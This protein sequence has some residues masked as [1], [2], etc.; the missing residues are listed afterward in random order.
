MAIVVPEWANVLFFVIIGE[1]MPQADED[2]AYRSHEAFKDF[3]G[4]LHKLSE[5]LEESIRASGGALPPEIADRYVRATRMV[6]DHGGKNYVLEFAKQL[7][8]V[9]EG[10]VQISIQIAENKVDIIVELAVLAMTLAFLDSL[11]AF[12]FGGTEAFAT[13]AKLASRYRILGM[14]TLLLKR[15]HLMPTISEMLE[16]MF[17]ALAS[18]LILMASAAPGRKPRGIDVKDLFLSGAAGALNSVFEHFFHGGKNIF[19]GLFKDKADLGPGLGRKFDA[20][21][22][23]PVP[24]PGK[25]PPAG[26]GQKI[27]ATSAD[28]TFDAA[29]AGLSEYLTGGVISGFNTMDFW[30]GAVSTLSMSALALG[31]D[32]LGIKMPDLSFLKHLNTD[33]YAPSKSGSAGGG[34]T[35]TGAG[36]Q[37]ADTHTGPAA[38]GPAAGPGLPGPHPGLAGTS[39][40]PVPT[41]SQ[42]D[43]PNPPAPAV[44]TGAGQSTGPATVSGGGSQSPGTTGAHGRSG[45]A[46]GAPAADPTGTRSPAPTEHDTLPAAGPFAD[47]ATST[48]APHPATGGRPAHAGVDAE[49]QHTP[50]TTGDLETEDT[51][52][53]QPGTGPVSAPGTGTGTSSPAQHGQ[54]AAPAPTGSGTTATVGAPTGATAAANPP[55][56]VKSGDTGQTSGA[57]ASANRNTERGGAAPGDT[58]GSDL[59]QAITAS[60]AAVTVTDASVPASDAPVTVTHTADP[61]GDVRP[62]EPAGARPGDQPATASVTTVSDPAGSPRPSGDPIDRVPDGTATDGTATDDGPGMSEPQ[63]IGPAATGIVAALAAP[64]GGKRKRRNDPD[65]DTD[66]QSAEPT[67]AAPDPTAT[68]E[69][70]AAP[71]P[72]PT[73]SRP[74]DTQAGA[75]DKG[76]TP[77]VVGGTLAAPHEPDPGGTDPEATDTADITDTTDTDDAITVVDGMSDSGDTLVGTEGGTTP[78]DGAKKAPKDPMPPRSREE[79]ARWI[80][81]LGTTAGAA[82]DPDAAPAV[83]KP[84][85]LGAVTAEEVTVAMFT[86]GGSDGDT[87][88][89]PPRPVTA[90]SV[91]EPVGPTAGGPALPAPA[92]FQ[93]DALVPPHETAPAPEPEAR[94]ERPSVED[95]GLGDRLTERLGTS[96]LMGAHVSRQDLADLEHSPALH[97]TWTLNPEATVRVGDAG[98]TPLDRARLLVRRPDLDADLAAELR[99]VPA[100]G[101]TDGTQAGTGAE[102]AGNPEQAPEPAGNPEQAPESAGGPGDRDGEHG[103]ARQAPAAGTRAGRR[104]APLRITV[105]DSAQTPAPGTTT[106]YT[107]HVTDPSAGPVFQHIMPIGVSD[108]GEPGTRDG[109][110]GAPRLVGVRQ[111]LGTPD[112]PALQV[113]ADG[114]LAVSTENE[115]REAFATPAAFERSRALLQAAGGSVRLVRDEEVSLTVRH[116]GTE[117]TLYRVRPE[118]LEDPTDVCRDLAGQILGGVPDH[119]VFRDPDGHTALGPMNAADGLKV[120]ELHHLAHAIVQ[121]V[122]GRAGPGAVPGTSWAAG[123]ARGRGAPAS[124]P[125]T[126]ASPVSATTPL[127]GQR[128][129]ALLGTGTHAPAGTRP[130]ID[131]NQD[132]WPAVGEGY[133]TQSIGSKDAEGRFTLEDHA[134]A[135]HPVDNPFGY[136][137]A[138]VVL[139]AEDDSS[140][141]TLENYA[142]RGTTQRALKDAVDRNLERHGDR[143]E[144]MR[145]AYEAE[146]S[147][148]TGRAR[149]TARAAVLATQAL[150]A[151]RDERAA[152]AHA[153][154]GDGEGGPTRTEPQAPTPA[155]RAASSALERYSGGRDLRTPGALWHMR[156]VD[157]SGQRTFHDQVAGLHEQDRPGIVVNPLTA[158]VVGAHGAPGEPGN[159]VTFAER[160][161]EPTEDDRRKLRALARRVARVGLWSH[162]NGLPLPAIGVSAGGNGV[163]DAVPAL[164]DRDRRARAT[165]ER[166]LDSA[167]AMFLDE[168]DQELS[169]LQRG[170]EP[171]TALTARDFEVRRE[172]RGRRLPETTGP[173]RAQTDPR[174]LRRQA[175]FT[176]EPHPTREQPAPTY[177]DTLDHLAQ[178]S[179]LIASFLDRSPR[180]PSALSSPGQQAG[181][182]LPFPA[183]GPTT[184]MSEHGV[185]GMLSVPPARPARP[186]SAP[187]GIDVGRLLSDIGAAEAADA[188][189]TS[190][191]STTSAGSTTSARSATAD[192]ERPDRGKGRAD[193]VPA[194]PPEDSAE[195]PDEATLRA[196]GILVEHRVHLRL[197]IGTDDDTVA[198][199]EVQTGWVERVAA[200]LGPDY[201]PAGSRDESVAHDVAEAI[202]R[203]RAERAVT[204]R[205]FAEL[206][207][208]R[209][210]TRPPRPGHNTGSPSRM[211]QLGSGGHGVGGL[212]WN[213]GVVERERALSAQYGVAIG[214][215][216]GRPNTHFSHS[217]LTRIEGVLAGLPADHLRGMVAITPGPAS[218]GGLTSEYDPNH[219]TVVVVAPY[220]LPSWIMNQF[221]RGSAWQRGA[222]DWA[223]MSEYRGFSSGGDRA[224]GLAGQRR[225][226][227]GGVSD[228][229]AQ[230]NFMKWLLRHEIGHHVDQLSNWMRDLIEQPHFGGWRVYGAGGY[231]MVVRNVLQKHGLT[232]LGETRGRNGLTLLS[233][234]ASA[235]SPRQQ[236]DRTQLFT[237][238]RAAFSDQSPDFRNR[239]ERVIRFGQLAFAHPWMLD[240]GGGDVLDIDGR[241]H[242]VSNDHQWISYLRSERDHHAVSNYQFSKPVEWFAEAY[243]AFYDPDPAPRLRMN[244]RTVHWF[245]SEL[246]A[247]L[248]HSAP[249]GPSGSSAPAGSSGGYGHTRAYPFRPDADWAAKSRRVLQDALVNAVERGEI[250]TAYT[251]G[252][253]RAL[254]AAGAGSAPADA[255]GGRE[256]DTSP[257]RPVFWSTPVTSLL[258]STPAVGPHDLPVRERRALTQRLREELFP[259]EADPTATETDDGIRRRWAPLFARA[260][261]D[262]ALLGAAERDRL[263]AG[264]GRIMAGRHQPPPIIRADV[265]PG[266]PEADYLALHDDMAA[267]IAD[268]LRRS[269]RPDLPPERRPAHLLSELLREDFGTR[270]TRGGVGGGPGK[271]LKKRLTGRRSDAGPS[272]AGPSGTG[273]FAEPGPSGHGAPGQYPYAQGTQPQSPYAPTSHAPTSYVQ[274]PYA[275]GT[276]TTP[277]APFA[278]A[279]AAAHPVP[280][281]YG[282]GSSAPHQ[283]AR[284]GSALVSTRPRDWPGDVGVQWREGRN[285]G[286]H[287]I[288]SGNGGQVVVKF[289]SDAASSVYADEFIRGVSDVHVPASRVLARGSTDA[290]AVESLIARQD[291]YWRNA[292]RALVAEYSHITVREYAE[293]TPLSRLSATERRA[294]AADADALRRIGG[295]MMVTDA[296]LGRPDRLWVNPEGGS[297]INWDNLLYSARLRRVTAIDNDTGFMDDGFN[298]AAHA[299]ELERNWTDDSI[300]HLANDLVTH[301]SGFASGLH[302]TQAAEVLDELE[303]GAREARG[304][305]GAR[306]LRHGPAVQRRFSDLLPEEEPPNA[307]LTAALAQYA[308]S[309]WDRRGA[310]RRPDSA[311]SEVAA[312]AATV[313]PYPPVDGDVRDRWADRFQ[314]AWQTLDRLA[315]GTQGRLLAEAAR[316]MAGRHR[317]PPP[318]HPGTQQH[319]YSV[320][321]HDITVLIAGTLHDYSDRPEAVHEAQAL[322]EQLRREFGTQA[323]RGA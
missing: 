311:L 288:G 212:L 216:S 265:V 86:G 42:A 144:E 154:A 158:V 30:G 96:R 253:V 125:A 196:V 108:A 11:A 198:F 230:G 66:E 306:A 26:T 103:S 295:L 39:P 194:D 279:R 82:H 303:Q 268:R 88:P 321:H 54:A 262:L 56:A 75:G 5:L 115:S 296:F 240:D 264:A 313:N 188:P 220:G 229:L 182:G 237:A 254:E 118:F 293:G 133:L 201:S 179:P 302:R 242:H 203:E 235:F 289:H 7:D 277:Q 59:D 309:R 304:R 214:P 148:V 162:R 117:R 205:R 184:P 318:D 177:S 222:M 68:R 102:P 249:S 145:A 166:R 127:P 15:I 77:A 159:R 151:V 112:H 228:V 269:P 92:P 234:V 286:V 79:I 287:V 244:P 257:A 122:D 27:A 282:S 35:M 191:A 129:G 273:G 290:R 109:D 51:P 120:S 213:Q 197:A 236:P 305:I 49:G 294:L 209:A 186:V 123:K 89:E 105:T 307:T 185:P 140:H 106:D 180:T 223:A 78:G 19:K 36:Q 164:A 142:R 267:L 280:Q 157:R 113:S 72:M 192:G 93:W 8:D 156:Y 149:A 247:L 218:D 130:R 260:H 121:A 104:P 111:D 48:G 17:T 87:A 81:G 259:Q 310:T 323:T 246:P 170:T 174:E 284:H 3:S 261:A 101:A 239:L 147:A 146:V 95:G 206:D 256:R 200:A 38:Q 53:T 301:H 55:A 13:A 208:L 168:L 137:Y 37:L 245:T 24:A 150:I 69:D 315:P 50:G 233:E 176:I 107:V 207:G 190:E 227:M 322:S 40:A 183:A 275:Q 1:R 316:I 299:A 204:D 60:D 172:N 226:V 193:H 263:L 167:H 99:T 97:V 2:L 278:A 31:A 231:I 44:D 57:N 210:G 297:V 258:P 165:G 314:R 251:N 33:P 274:S 139:A 161:V 202:A 63:R 65:G 312:A 80:D 47:G 272:G 61:L 199:R 317:A 126:S 238:L 219:Q 319:P 43:A 128:Y 298:A 90:A 83:G 291:T 181:R 136:H 163:R 116:N 14:M 131:I 67:S 73:V 62:G 100:L 12:V 20:V 221:N 215:S 34:R 76:A 132:A 32:S 6:T 241:I 85:P 46:P 243:A 21:H 248:A 74:D 175:V 29:S 300:E 135:F 22:T 160:A 169:H 252:L 232:D 28:Q 143:L 173:S 250:G 308:H 320:L 45:P 70:V 152:R 18:R 16:E 4:Q 41:V 270:A 292:H 178:G 23:P 171:A 285:G 91:P 211:L 266:S 64:D 155:E 52:A 281:S 138:A 225:Q 124:S 141:V 10:R 94:S 114:T 271:W 283:G 119:L 58:A 71:V 134:G 217:T 255:A 189:T 110:G 153:G 276:W 187:A 25:K 9:A 195:R 98:L 84:H 224:L